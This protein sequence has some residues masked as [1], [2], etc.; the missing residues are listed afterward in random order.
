MASSGRIPQKRTK[1]VFSVTSTGSFIGRTE[2]T[3]EGGVSSAS[4]SASASASSSTSTS[5]LLGTETE[6]LTEGR[7]DG[8]TASPS[9]SPSNPI[10]TTTESCTQLKNIQYKSMLM[11]GKNLAMLSEG[12]SSP[13]VTKTAEADKVQSL[14]TTESQVLKEEVPWNRLSKAQKIKLLAD[15]GHMYSSEHSL[16][17]DDS[18]QL[19]TYLRDCLERKK[20]TRARDVQYNKHM[21][22][23]ED[24]PGL[25]YTPTITGGIATGPAILTA[26]RKFSLKR[27][28][29][30]KNSTLKNLAPKKVRVSA[31]TTATSTSTSTF[32]TTSATTTFTTT[33]TPAKIE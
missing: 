4:A 10:P 12:G 7:V 33:S 32:T 1:T 14:L 11:N 30:A 23:I 29:S 5:V 22:M 27:D 15:F 17:D 2:E 3:T 28:D 16:T 25:I 8:G 20:F 21:G 13:L 26:S 6:S 24:I 9:S 19:Q 31:I 18:A